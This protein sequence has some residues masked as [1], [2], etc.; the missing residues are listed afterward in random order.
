MKYNTAITILSCLG[1]MALSSCSNAVDLS[2][3]SSQRSPNGKIMCVV[4]VSSA[5]HVKDIYDD[6]ELTKNMNTWIKFD[7]KI[8][9]L[10]DNQFF[11]ATDDKYN[12]FPSFYPCDISLKYAKSIASKYYRKNE[13]T[14]GISSIDAYEKGLSRLKPIDEDMQKYLDDTG[15]GKQQ[16]ED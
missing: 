16:K 12:H 5:V 9:K 15:F 4:K 11:Q 6:D 13:I 2:K 1:S 7:S 10:T 8:N 3:Y 14:L